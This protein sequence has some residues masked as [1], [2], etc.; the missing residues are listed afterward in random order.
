MFFSERA[1][2]WPN[3]FFTELRRVFNIGIGM[4]AVV[5]P[6]EE[7]AAIGALKTAGRDAWVIGEIESGSGVR[8]TA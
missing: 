8:Y 6:S 4:I 1:Q 5:D 7:L 2:S 3:N